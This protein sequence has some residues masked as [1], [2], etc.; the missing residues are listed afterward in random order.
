MLLADVASQ[1]FASVYLAIYVADQHAFRG[2]FADPL[3]VTTPFKPSSW[4]QLAVHA[5]N[6]FSNGLVRYGPIQGLTL[7]GFAMA[8]QLAVHGLQ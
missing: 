3:Q 2:P 6:H 4:F 5:N 7:T 8:P 1:I